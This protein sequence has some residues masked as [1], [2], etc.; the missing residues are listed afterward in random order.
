MYKTRISARNLF[1]S[2]NTQT[3]VAL[4]E[5]QVVD[6]NDNTPLFTKQTQDLVIRVDETAQRGNQLATLKVSQCV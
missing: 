3:H 5:V 6:V 2:S 4:L 1:S